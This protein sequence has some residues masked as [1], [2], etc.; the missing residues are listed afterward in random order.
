MSK[1]A[2]PKLFAL[3]KIQHTV[4]FYRKLTSELKIEFAPFHDK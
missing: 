1:I 4:K 3:K 2:A